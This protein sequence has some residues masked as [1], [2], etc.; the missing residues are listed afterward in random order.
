MPPIW[1]ASVPNLS[2]IF[3]EILLANALIS[4]KHSVCNLLA[5][6][7]LP[8]KGFAVPFVS[9]RARP[10][11]LLFPKIPPSAPYCLSLI[12]HNECKTKLR[13]GMTWMN[14]V[15][16][17]KWTVAM[18]LPECVPHLNLPPHSLDPCVIVS[19]ESSSAA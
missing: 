2:L 6:C 4:P 10:C 11:P 12:K 15:I 19:A 7:P 1:H 3:W 9:E 14:I 17:T 18:P 8:W 13:Y 16:V 5:Y